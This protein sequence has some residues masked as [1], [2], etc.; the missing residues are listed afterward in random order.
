ML[1]LMRTFP[2]GLGELIYWLVPT[3]AGVDF[4]GPESKIPKGWGVPYGQIS[5]VADFPRLGKLF[6]S[7]YGGDGVSTFGW[8]DMRG[9]SAIAKDDMGGTAANRVTSGGS[10]IAGNTLGASGGAENVALSTT[11]L[12]SHAHSD[13]YQVTTGNPITVIGF[14]SG[15]SGT[16]SNSV[17][18][19][20]SE[21]G[22][23]T[24]T[25]AAGSGTAHQNMIPVIVCNYMIKT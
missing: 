10:G 22:A 8:P 21:S 20:V 23:G 4:W 9:R 5:R 7:T 2:R 15:G 25:G 17:L 14:S 19:S 3:G 24:T 13:Y 11:H 1:S 18:T 6:G 16:T 12:A